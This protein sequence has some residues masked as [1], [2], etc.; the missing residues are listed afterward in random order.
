[1]LSGLSSLLDTLSAL[2]SF[3]IHTFESLITLVTHVP[4]Y[5]AF[6]TSAITVLPSIVIPFAL[7]SISLGAVLFILGR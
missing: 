4:Q 2:G 7:A 3:L 5:T 6:I 1:M